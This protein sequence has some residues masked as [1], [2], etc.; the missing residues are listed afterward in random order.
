MSEEEF[1][2]AL[3][4][5]ASDLRLAI[6]AL[7]STGQPFC[8]IGGLAVNRY[9]E[10]VVTLDADF[11]IAAAGGLVEALAAR[12]F[13]VQ[14]FPHSI[15]AQLPGSRLRVQITVNSRYAG[16]P[17]R[18]VPGQVL[19][20]EM[21]VASLADLVQGKLWALHDPERRSSKKAKDEADLV[22]IC[23]SHPAMLVLIPVGLIQRID[24]MRD[25][26]GVKS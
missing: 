12:G 13:R 24:M 7:R 3:T 22:R 18:A 19:G 14:E 25:E 1:L 21:P 23:E 9:V 15:N 2:A 17:G 26:S 11:A 6:E 10:P 8:L 16:F 5:N 20:H 4:G